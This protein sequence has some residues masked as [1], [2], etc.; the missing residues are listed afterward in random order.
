MTNLK[1]KI[2]TYG[3]QM[4]ISDSERIATC[5]QAIGGQPTDQIEGADLIILNICSVRQSAVDRVYGQ[6][7]NFN[8][9]KSQNPQLKI[10]LTGC[11][12]EK[13]KKK[14]KDKIDLIF[15]IKDFYK[16][17][18]FG[19][20]KK[21][22]CSD[23]HYF[24]I[25]P[26][27]QSK[28]QATVPIMTG[29]N[30]FCSYCVVPYLRGQEY[31][32]PSQ[33]IIKEVK[34]MIKK[35]Y[36]EITLLGQNVNSYK[37]NFPKLL[38]EINSLNGNFWLR[39]ITSHPKDMSDDLITAVAKG[40]K[41]CEY[42][43][44]PVQA[45]DDKILKAMNRRYTVNQYLKLIEK[46]RKNIP[47]VAITTDTI[48]GFPGESKKQFQNTVEL[49]KKAKFDMAYISQYSPR[50]QTAAFK[51]KDNVSREEKKQREKALTEVLK[52]TALENNQKLIGKEAEV[53]VTET[54][55]G[56]LL[57]KTRTAKKVKTQI[58]SL[59][60]PVS[61][62]IGQFVKIKINQAGPWGLK[63]VPLEIL[64]F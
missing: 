36:K 63:G 26:S 14:L 13:D 44:L 28:F 4:N 21:E 27:Y 7:K 43:H 58:S 20:N 57:A 8:K 31:S 48:V 22:I 33:E 19:V 56:F 59:R 34:E 41:I 24:K 53:L 60:S 64:H 54:K 32:R 46:I 35:G 40:E 1:Y 37:Y 49:F 18:E 62:L 6:I 45:G 5:L 23:G 47:G 16:L 38:Q 12:L 51:L 15:N 61:N 39:F 3:C 11:L 9:L 42:I 52:K 17:K 10:C 25:R 50:S 30:N 2:I 55:N 29:C